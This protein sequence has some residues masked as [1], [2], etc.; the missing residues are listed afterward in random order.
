M[1]PVIMISALVAAGLFLWVLRGYLTDFYSSELN[2]R[3]QVRA[4]I[5]NG[6]LTSAI[7]RHRLVPNVL[8]RDRAM[9]DALTTR[10][11]STTSARLIQINSELAAHNLFLL[12]AEGQVVASA[13]RGLLGA[14]HDDRPYFREAARENS[15]IFH[16]I[17]VT[18]N[19]LGFFFSHPIRASGR[20]IGVI[21]VE[22]SLRN[23]ETSWGLGTGRVI[24][25]NSEDVVILSSHPAWRYRLLSPLIEEARLAHIRSRQLG[26]LEIIPLSW[27]GSQGEINVDGRVFLR[28]EVPV[29]FRGW[30]V[31]YLAPLSDVYDSV[32]AIIALVIMA[33]ALFA[34]TIFW[35]NSKRAWRRFLR[36]QVESDQL[37]D[38]NQ[39][40]SAEIIERRRVEHTLAKAEQSLE[41]ASKLAALGQMSAAVSH[42]L[43]Q[44]LAAMR[45]Y[46]AGAR[47]LMQR[48]RMT[49]A[50]SSIQRIDDL[51]S[52]MA[53][54]TRQ[55][56]SFARK[57]DGGARP[58]DLREAVR[59]SMSVMTPQFGHLKID[60]KLDIPS[61]PV[62]AIAD[63]L[64]VEQ[65][66]VNLLK[67]ALDAIQDEERPTVWLT[68]VPGPVPVIRVIDNGP[69]LPTDR[70]SLFEPF[71]TTKAP[72]KGL[73]LGLAIS[74]GIAEDLGGKLTARNGPGGGA[75]FELTMPAAE[76]F[77]T[78]AE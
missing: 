16:A 75:C 12:D 22:L 20:L 33:F 4:A 57:G 1:R 52:R 40:L 13:D 66:I 69:G 5:F 9:I 25:T 50:L 71:F 8:S 34:A 68:V 76:G 19:K 72:G 43:N 32:N 64:R 53:G 41:Q 35:F 18:E 17:S 36:L 2:T 27:T 24:V 39:R 49:E 74:A 65:I 51:I 42:E 56:K 78:A 62:F 3:S 30:T 26:G 67:N 7:Q 59:G 15:T 70:K 54:L 60:L 61:E 47:L 44:P 58:L 10:Q 45:T 14:V 29:G 23:L 28:H 11:F 37:R 21:V 63:Q 6:S 31:N 48:N 55:L 46:V 38:L 73:G 77:E